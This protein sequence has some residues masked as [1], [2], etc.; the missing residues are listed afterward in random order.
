MAVVGSVTDLEAQRETDFARWRSA[1][2]TRWWL[3][4]GALL[5]GALGGA[6][7][8]F[9]GSSAYEASVLVAPGDVFSPSGA[10]I[11]NYVSSPRGI[12]DLVTSESALRTAA[13]KAALRVDQLIGHV[14]TQS[15]LTGAGVVAARGTDGCIGNQRGDGGSEYQRGPH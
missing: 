8:S 3:V 15:L 4:A 11:L 5:V 7:F 1:L 6:I 9:T 12:N 14:S 13:A 2:V 10:P